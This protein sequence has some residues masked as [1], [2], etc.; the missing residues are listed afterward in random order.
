VISY[1]TAGASCGCVAHVRVLGCVLTHLIKTYIRN[2]AATNFHVQI[3]THASAPP[4][5]EERAPFQLCTFCKPPRPS[6]IDVTSRRYIIQWLYKWTR[7]LDGVLLGVRKQ[8][9]LSG[10]LKN[11]VLKSCNFTLNRVCIFMALW[12]RYWSF[13]LLRRVIFWLYTSV[14]EHAVFIFS[15]GI[16]S[17][18]MFVCN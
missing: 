13:A 5:S 12:F 3:I 6:D 10:A 17:F 14:S 8:T 2:I 18:E 1:T 15:V 4:H 9:S 16:C 11:F 7:I